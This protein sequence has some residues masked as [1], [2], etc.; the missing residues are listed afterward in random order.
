MQKLVRKKK[1]AL[2]PGQINEGLCLS[3]NNTLHKYRLYNNHLSN[4]DGEKDLAL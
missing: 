4:H 2:Q 1:D 3:R